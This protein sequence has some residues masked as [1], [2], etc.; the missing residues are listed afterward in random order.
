MQG[1]V[2]FHPVDLQFFDELIE[3]LITGDKV[4]PEGYLAEA[5]RIRQGLSSARRY[6]RAL[7]YAMTEGAEPPPVL[8]QKTWI[9]AVRARVERM[10]F[11]P[12]VVTQKALDLV[13]PELHLNGRPYFISEGSA[14]RVADILHDYRFASDF[15]AADALAL[16]QLIGMDAEL[17]RGLT[18]E[19]SEPMSSDMAYR[20]ELLGS[21]KGVYDLSKAAR[22]GEEWG[23]LG[24]ARRSAVSVLAEELPWRV[25]ALYSKVVPF[26]SAHDVDGLETICRLAGV[27]P[28]E[29]M[30]PAWRLLGEASTEYPEVHGA[31]GVEL[32][33]E[34]SVG[35]FVS[36]AD[37]PELQAFLSTNGSKIIQ[38][39]SKHGEGPACRTLLRK[40]RECVTYAERHGMGY[41]EASGIL[42][43]DLQAPPKAFGS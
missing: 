24:Q 9:G 38:V 30:V 43:P 42:P 7:E 25:V 37:V 23:R 26:W 6:K 11:E 29:M 8:P 27:N 39:A 33:S 31:M 32:S 15:K 34:Q 41:L 14:E 10:T 13:D 28:P 12:D 40:I 35:A 19:E 22:D 2:T 3:P 20:S 18:L 1:S 4:N 36:P 5:I 21:L 16:E 17:A